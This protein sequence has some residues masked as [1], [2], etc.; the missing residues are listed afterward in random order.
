MLPTIVQNL[1]PVF[2]VIALGFFAR[3]RGF[4]P[5]AFSEAANR[6]VYTIGIPLLIFGQVAPGDF[7]RNFRPAQIAA[8]VAAVLAAAALGL[9]LAALLRLPAG[10]A[11]TFA[12]DCF[13]GNTGFIA[14]AVLLYVLGPEGL[15]AG[16]VLAGFTMLVNNTLSLVLFTFAPRRRRE[17]SWRT[18][19]GF[20]GNPIVA[21]TLLGLLFSALR[22]P[23]PAVA[24]RSIKIV[25]DMALPVALLIIGGSLGP[26]I[27][28]RLP[29]AHLA[30]AVKLAVLPALGVLFLRLFDA[31]AGV[32]VPA[33]ILLGSPAAT[34]SY[35]MAREMDGDPELAAATVTVSTVLSIV[36]YTLW[37]VAL[38]QPG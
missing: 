9:L 13:H 2:L 38:G 6:L 22:I 29:L 24:A 23:L 10:T 33:V 3:R 1:S 5:D 11:L 8:I 32:E 16:S 18:L 17:L 4:L 15:A 20:L 19:L 14:L 12:Q 21:A 27:R 35:V 30:S 36:S 31:G 26:A 34:L 7:S 28:A 37:L 25:S